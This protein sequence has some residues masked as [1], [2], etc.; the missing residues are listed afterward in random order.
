MQTTPTQKQNSQIDFEL[1]L[2]VQIRKQIVKALS[3]FQLIEP[4]DKIMVCVSGG[5]DSSILLALLTEIQRRAEFDFQIEAAILDQKQPGFDGQKF[6]QW[7]KDC[8]FLN[9][10]RIQSSKKKFPKEIP[11]VHSVHV[12]VAQFCMILPQIKVLQKW[13]WDTTVMM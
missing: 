6:Y 5:K 2:A 3:D 10:I 12:C 8:I 13:P 9:V 7:V 11:I 1:P 4:N